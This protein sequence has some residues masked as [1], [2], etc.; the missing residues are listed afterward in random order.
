MPSVV[1]NLRVNV[2][3]LWEFYGPGMSRAKHK[4][5]CTL[6]LYLRTRLCG[7][8]LFGTPSTSVLRKLCW[9]R[10]TYYR[11]VRK[12]LDA[13]LITRDPWGNY[14]LLRSEEFIKI[15]NRRK[16]RHKCT[17]RIKRD[18]TL[19]QIQE[20]VRLKFM[21]Q[22]IAQLRWRPKKKGAR[23]FRATATGGNHAELFSNGFTQFSTDQMALHLGL[24]VSSLTRWRRSQNSHGFRSILRKETVGNTE[25][26]RKN[27]SLIGTYITKGGQVVK[28]YPSMYRTLRSYR[29]NNTHDQK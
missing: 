17:L 27:L 13:K 9:S 25:A 18:S 28:V 4:R 23:K 12:L 15:G 1:A 21:E 2:N 11:N 14:A 5:A 19:S 22:R 8:V 26:H 16:V 10:P 24:S 7:A 3:A 20:E 29:S 6:Y